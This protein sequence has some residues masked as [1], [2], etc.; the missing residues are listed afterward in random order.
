MNNN[1]YTTPIDEQYKNKIEGVIKIKYKDDIKFNICRIIYESFYDGSYQYVF[2]PYYDVLDALPPK[3]SQGIP[4]LNLEKRQTL[5]YRVNVVPSFISERTMDLNRENLKEEMDK[6]CMDEYNPLEW[7]IRT[8]SEYSGDNLIVERYRLPRNIET[9]KYNDL[10]YG[11]TLTTLNDISADIHENTKQ[12]LYL[13]GSGVNINEENLKIDGHNRTSILQLL[14]HQFEIGN[15]H[16][17]NKVKDD[18]YKNEEVGTHKGQKKIID[19]FV[20]EEVIKEL[21][22]KIISEHEAMEILN[23]RT[24][25]TL[26]KKIREYKLSKRK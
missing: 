23:I 25:A 5:Y 18:A 12:L 1:V 21:E 11:D 22:L 14:L 7:L 19:N 9:I 26:N 8:E 15:N 20:M 16:I 4:G 3:I 6:V 10:I 13:V 17:K 24:K 2:E